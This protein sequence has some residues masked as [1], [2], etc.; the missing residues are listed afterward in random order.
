MIDIHTTTRL[1][2]RIDEFTELFNV[3]RRTVYNWRRAGKLSFIYV[4]QECRIPIA[5]VRALA[6][7]TKSIQTK[8]HK[9]G[10]PGQSQAPPP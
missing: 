8:H 6:D 1:N 9:L 7:G 5:E 10:Q 2:I 3:S 4:G